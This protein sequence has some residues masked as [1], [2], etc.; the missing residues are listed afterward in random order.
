MVFDELGDGVFRRR[1]ASLDLNVGLVLGEDGV[2]VV[3]TRATHAQADVLIEELGSFTSLPVRWVVNTHWHWDHAFGNSRFK[4]AEIWGHEL[5]GE[6]LRV[7]GDEMKQGA[8]AWLPETHY[9]AI[10]DVEIVP[11]SHTFS[12]RASLAI[13]RAVELSYHGL[14]HTDAD[15]VVAVPDSGV[16]FMGDM[17]EES[18]PPNFGDSYPTTWP[19]TLRL[20]MDAVEGVIVPG[21]GDVVDRSFVQGQHEELVAV[22]EVVTRVLDGEFGVDEAV[23]D[24]PYPAEVMR[25]AIERALTL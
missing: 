10:D 12:S 24:G 2:L 18:A 11:P 19:F 23:S 3:D 8:K 6:A 5:C 25:S 14:A 16:A 21:H 13:G 22:A 17:I 9:G 15:I 20:A 1:Y 4:R 7:R